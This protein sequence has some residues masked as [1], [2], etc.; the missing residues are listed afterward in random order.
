MSLV[1]RLQKGGE[2]KVGFGA[3]AIACEARAFETKVTRFV[4]S[5]VPPIS[6]SVLGNFVYL[7]YEYT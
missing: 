4:F 5:K 7:D 2:A 3:T 1:S 6:S